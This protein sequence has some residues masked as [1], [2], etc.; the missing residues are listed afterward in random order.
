QYL[1][2]IG[3]AD[4][5][6]PVGDPAFLMD[7][8]KPTGIDDEMPIEKNAIGINLS[9]FMAKFATGWNMD[10]WTKISA[11]IIDA[12]ATTAEAPIY[13]IPHVTAKHTNDH[14]FMQNVLSTIDTKKI[15]VTLV[16]PKYN[17]AE[18]KWIISR[19][20]IFAGA[21]MHSTIAA[22]STNVP[23]LSLAY[24]IKAH[25]INR[26]IFGHLNYCLNPGELNTK[27]V[28]SRIKIMLDQ[29]TE[30]K[31][32]LNERIPRIKSMA[33]GAGTRLRQFTDGN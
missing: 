18:T 7:P 32:E 12:V 8:I 20:A 31:K 23:T 14:E 2:D 26:D 33:L 1:K 6:Y 16:P 24:S 4:N 3:V 11:S 25:G 29:D 9:P 17:A 22:L 15:K 30:I 10:Q 19:M 27:T 28:S 21:R 5:V 13:L